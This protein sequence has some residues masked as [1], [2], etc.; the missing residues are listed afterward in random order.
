MASQSAEKLEH[1]KLAIED[2][3]VSDPTIFQKNRQGPI[4][5]RLRAE[6]PVHYCRESRY[7]P[8]WSVTRYQDII[9][10]DSNHQ[11]FS[12]ANATSLDETRAKGRGPN[13]TPVG[14]FLGMDPPEH[15]T[16]RKIVSPALA[17]A[18][19]ARFEHLIRE[20]TRN[21]LAGLPIGEEFDW[22]QTVSVE[23][24]M[25]MLATLLGV[26]FDERKQLKRWSDV[27][28]GVPGDGVVESWEQRDSELKEM[29][30]AFLTLRETRR[31]EEP[32]SDL[33]SMLAHSPVA[34]NMSDLEFASNVSILVVGGNDTTRN[35]MSAGILAFHD[36]PDQWAKLKANPALV[37]S[38]VPEIIRWHTPI[39]SQG[40]RAT[41]DHELGGKVIRKGDKVMM[42]Y[43]SGNRDESA[44]P[45]AGQFIID[46][47][48]PR[49]HLSFGFGI[50]RCLGNRLA[51]MQLRIFLEEILANDWARIEVT[52]PVGY[53]LSS[54]VRGINRLRVRIHA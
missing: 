11:V 31:M 1:D 5:A 45:D 17:P 25:M 21:A 18:N 15:D 46:R 2:I 28:A 7:G 50:H 24:T 6:D 32:S 54:S 37:D 49:Q 38:A 8:Y 41:Q 29:T 4:F 44:I 13:A 10:V 43:V 48:R 3:D 53:A 19:L 22:A 36:H 9:A 42:W 47:A 39:M 34:Q 27:I 23:L 12:S 26:P 30:R 20:R 35:S 14:G 40:R 16:Q 51:E 33:L 52:E